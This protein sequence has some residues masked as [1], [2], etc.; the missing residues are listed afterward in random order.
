[1][2]QALKDELASYLGELMHQKESCYD[3]QKQDEITRKMNAV[4]C[5]LGINEKVETN[6]EQMLKIV[7][8]KL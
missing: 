8:N 4:Y 7:K 6:L 3:W 2:N 1:M 5:L